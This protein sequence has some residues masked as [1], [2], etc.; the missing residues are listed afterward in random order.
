MALWGTIINAIAII[1]GGLLGSLIPRISEG[2]RHTVMQGL[3]LVIAVL[4]ISMALK[5]TNLLI[6]II[7]LV[8]GGILGELFRIESRLQQ[9][10]LWLERVIQRGGKT[11]ST[12]SSIAEGF[13]TATLVY[14]IGA[15]AILGAIDS[16]LRNNHDILY[17]KSM[18]DGISAIIFAS[19]LGIGVVFSSIPV[20]VYQ[21][22]IALS[23]SFIYLFVSNTEL[24]A[25]I[26]EVTAVGGVLIIGLGINILGIIKINVANLLPSIIIAAISVLITINF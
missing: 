1:A 10:G 24:N 18:L 21:G 12:K 19:T 26:T 5:S 3:G 22:I 2:M 9:L 8:L 25:I 16:G 11:E 23:A 15:M 6:V 20:F 4:G 7:S 13:V 14:C 17:T